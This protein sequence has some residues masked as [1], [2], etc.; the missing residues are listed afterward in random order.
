VIPGSK[1]TQKTPTTA[2]LLILVNVLISQ[3]E[4]QQAGRRLQESD[5]RSVKK[6]P[7]IAGGN[8]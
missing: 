6:M 1:Q 5:K 4:V 7:C 8:W 3:M 2:L